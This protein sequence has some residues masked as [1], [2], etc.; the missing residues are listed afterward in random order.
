MMYLQLIIHYNITIVRNN[1][2]HK[3]GKANHSSDMALGARERR[4]AH[5][6]MYATDL[7]SWSTL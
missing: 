5:A 6:P 7:L 1:A 2:P 3:N 4:H